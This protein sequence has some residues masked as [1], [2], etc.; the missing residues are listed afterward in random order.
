MEGQDSQ[1]TVLPLPSVTSLFLYSQCRRGG[2]PVHTGPLCFVHQCTMYHQWGSTYNPVNTDGEFSGFYPHPDPLFL[3]WHRGISKQKICFHWD[4]V[5]RV[6]I[7]LQGVIGRSRVSLYTFIKFRAPAGLKAEKI[8]R[9]C[10]IRRNKVLQQLVFINTFN[11]FSSKQYFTR[12]RS[13]D[14]ILGDI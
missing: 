2:Y 4:F 5:S 6:G 11:G 13:R 8:N 9:I 12:I 10:P 14:E 3:T 1:K 7:C